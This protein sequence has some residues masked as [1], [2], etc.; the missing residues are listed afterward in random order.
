MGKR[1]LFVKVIIIS[2]LALS[3]LGCGSIKNQ[4]A[5]SKG[6]INTKNSGNSNIIAVVPTEEITEVEDGFS[7]VRYDGDYGFDEF[8]MGGGASSDRDVIDYLSE[9]LLSGLDLGFTENVFG[10]STIAVQT[11][12]GEALF[13]RNFDWNHCEAMSVISHPENGYASISTVNTDFISQGA[14]GG[15]AGMALKKDEIKTIAA[16]YAPLDGVNEEGFAVSVNM[17]QDSDSIGQ[18]TEKPDITTTTAIRL[19]LDKAATVEEALALLGQYDMHASMG[20]M[21]H[22]A[23][24]DTNGRSAAVEYVDNEMIV[25]ETPVLTNFYLAEGE[26]NGIGTAQSHTRY[27]M[28]MEQVEQNGQM[29]AG[30]VRDALS[31]VSK[32]NF[33]EFESTEWSVIFNQTE[34]QATYYHRENYE[35]G[36]VFTIE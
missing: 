28:L 35:Q 1:V 15:I 19:L 13:G 26:K 7:V 23:L 9:T 6:D 22:F 24:A 17:I 34:G 11:P 16:L 25:T 27:E 3:L 33:G 36:Y 5:Q 30:D 32:G 14:G 8:L 31:S 4:A 18:D 12:E 29:S 21:V 10:C 20:M 2:T